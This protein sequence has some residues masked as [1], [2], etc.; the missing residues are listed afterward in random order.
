MKNDKLIESLCFSTGIR[1]GILHTGELHALSYKNS[2]AG[3]D[4]ENY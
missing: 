4:C 1:E 2:M 3:D